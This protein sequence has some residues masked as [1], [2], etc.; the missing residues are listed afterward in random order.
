MALI[1]SIEKDG[2]VYLSSLKVA[3]ELKMT[4][5]NF[6]QYLYNRFDKRNIVTSGIKEG[7]YKNRRG[8]T[9]RMRWLSEDLV[10]DVEC[11][12]L[13]RRDTKEAKK[14]RPTEIIFGGNLEW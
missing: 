3:A 1:E 10:A 11:S 14:I 12:V 8:V 5:S 6:L 4:H 2:V 7:E 9:Q 13:E